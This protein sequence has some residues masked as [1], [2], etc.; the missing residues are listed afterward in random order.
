MPNYTCLTYTGCPPK[1]QSQNN[2][3]APNSGNV[4]VPGWLITQKALYA[5]TIK[6]GFEH[7]SRIASGNL[8]NRLK[9]CISTRPKT[10]FLPQKVNRLGQKSG[11]PFGFGAP[12]RNSYI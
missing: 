4:N 5:W 6:T 1:V 7:R 8:E 9:T 2:Q 11:S 3:G 10:Q 12:P